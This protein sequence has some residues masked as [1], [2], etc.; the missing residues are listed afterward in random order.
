[1]PSILEV[2][3]LRHFLCGAA[4]EE[5]RDTEEGGDGQHDRREAWD[6]LQRETCL[7][8]D[9]AAHQHPHCDC[10]QIHS[11][12]EPQWPRHHHVNIYGLF[13]RPEEVSSTPCT[14]LADIDMNC[15]MTQADLKC[16]GYI[17]DP[18]QINPI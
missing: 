12:W 6:G 16:L 2:V 3:D 11:T 8:H 4:H 10:W 7:L 15:R 1:M 13:K 17:K 5:E 14:V 18:G 9:D